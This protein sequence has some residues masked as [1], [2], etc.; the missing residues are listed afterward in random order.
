MTTHRRSTNKPLRLGLRRPV[1]FTKYER[2]MAV[3]PIILMIS[4]MIF[5]V[6]L[7]YTKKKHERYERMNVFPW[8]EARLVVKREPVSTVIDCD[9]YLDDPKNDDNIFHL[10]DPVVSGYDN[11]S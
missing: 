11:L 3:L 9:Y 10:S 2:F 1:V 6:I 7:H 8:N 5:I 4:F